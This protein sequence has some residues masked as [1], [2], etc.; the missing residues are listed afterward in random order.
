MYAGKSSSAACC[1]SNVRRYRPSAKWASVNGTRSLALKKL[2]IS[3]LLNF[4]FMGIINE[5]R[6]S[7]TCLYVQD[8]LKKHHS[9]MFT[10]IRSWVIC[11]YRFF[12]TSFRFLRTCKH[13][14]NFER[15][16]RFTIFT[17]ILLSYYST[18]VRLFVSITIEGRNTASYQGPFCY[19]DMA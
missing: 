16:I 2:N 6:S 9:L 12:V 10:V 1:S 15:S 11:K 14:C 18:L 13:L 17:I 4:L 7:K 3:S 19:L 5:P 8:L